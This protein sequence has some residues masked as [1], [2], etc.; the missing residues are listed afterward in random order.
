[1]HG[2]EWSDVFRTCACGCTAF[3]RK[4]AW[5]SSARG[6]RQTADKG[7][8]QAVPSG[9]DH[10]PAWPNSAAGLRM[11]TTLAS[12]SRSPVCRYTH[13]YR[14]LKHDWHFVSKSRSCVTVV[15]FP[16]TLASPLVMKP[17]LSDTLIMTEFA[18]TIGFMYQ[19][20]FNPIL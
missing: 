1:M 10:D 18:N 16:V 20:L 8:V 2:N 6:L 14:V 12:L 9:L 7:A 11:M 5:T 15:A 3:L 13:L 19:A 4:L 17:R